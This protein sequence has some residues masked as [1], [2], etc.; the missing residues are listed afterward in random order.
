MTSVVVLA[1]LAQTASVPGLPA[2]PPPAPEAIPLAAPQPRPFRRTGRGL[3]LELA[4]GSAVALPT[5]F[6]FEH[7]PGSLSVPEFG[8]ALIGVGLLTAMTAGAVGAIALAGQAADGPRES[9]AWPTLGLGV[10]ALGGFVAGVGFVGSVPGASGS[11]WETYAVLLAV[12]FGA[13]VGYNL[14][15][16]A[17]ATLAGA[18][19]RTRR[20][21]ALSGLLGG[22]TLGGSGLEVAFQLDDRIGLAL[23]AISSEGAGAEFSFRLQAAAA[24]G[25][26]GSLFIAAGPHLTA[27][28]VPASL[29]T[30][31]EQTATA[32]GALAA[33]GWELRGES[34]LT[35]GIELSTVY[36]P[37]A[38]NISQTNSGPFY[39]G[40]A[41]RLGYAR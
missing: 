9:A 16:D 14:A 19:T 4:A 37:R 21:L 10:G 8:G 18:S 25:P 13:V 32:V 6:L 31:V 5:A 27:G 12:P 22:D 38:R 7:P 3:L 33:V 40:G 20:K 35:F 15:A 17:D 23:Q 39:P 36:E 41:I 26:R 28:A 1:L 11:G 34:G 29:N 30:G 2:A 24:A